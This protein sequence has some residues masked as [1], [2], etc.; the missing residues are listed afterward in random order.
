[1]VTP[2]GKVLPEEWE[3]LMLGLPQLSEPLGATH[4][5][6]AEHPPA[7]ASNTML[8]GQLEKLGA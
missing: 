4:V 7:A 6:A 1:M 3:A 8:D 2:T 5:T